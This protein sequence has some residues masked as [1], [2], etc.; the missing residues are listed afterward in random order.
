MP[1]DRVWRGHFKGGQLRVWGSQAETAVKCGL[2][3]A[4]NPGV[5]G[6]EG[7]ATKKKEHFLFSS[8]EDSL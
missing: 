7:E 2:G 4:R 5:G 3:V 1:E 6:G 8:K